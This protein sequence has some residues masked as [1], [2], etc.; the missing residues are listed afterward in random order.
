MATDAFEVAGRNW[1]IRWER[2]ML[3]RALMIR[4]ERTRW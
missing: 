4:V 2:A 3:E 1:V